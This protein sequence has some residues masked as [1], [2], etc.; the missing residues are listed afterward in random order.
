VSDALKARRESERT[1]YLDG[2][3]LQA[4]IAGG[5]GTS[6]L[7]LLLVPAFFLQSPDTGPGG[8]QT[9]R[10]TLTPCRAIGCPRMG[11]LIEPNGVSWCQMHFPVAGVA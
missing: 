8:E 9:Y 2:S 5:L 6:G 11:T 4:S 10:I 7:V 3:A 1:L